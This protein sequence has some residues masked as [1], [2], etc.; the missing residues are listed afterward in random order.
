MLREEG[1]RWVNVAHILGVSPITLLRRRTEFE[2]PVSYNFD[3]IPDN[4]LDNL[5]SGILHV[6]PQAG[7]HFVQEALRSRDFQIQRERIRESIVRVD[8]IIATLRNGRRVV[9]RR[10]HVPSPNAL[11]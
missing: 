11:W 9:R 5:V 8:P 6:T 2:M 4:V 7:R 1:F 10:H 3:E